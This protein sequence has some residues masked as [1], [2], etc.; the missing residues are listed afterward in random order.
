[1]SAI[2]IDSFPFRVQSKMKKNSQ[3][4][5]KRLMARTMAREGQRKAKRHT[6]HGNQEKGKRPPGNK[7]KG[8]S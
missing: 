2:R 4:P 6:T 7:K 3:N 8:K 1:L 5:N